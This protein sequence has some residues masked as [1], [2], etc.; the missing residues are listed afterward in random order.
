M[1]VTI[2]YG[3]PLTTW[4]LEHVELPIGKTNTPLRKEFSLAPI[5][6]IVTLVLPSTFV[7]MVSSHA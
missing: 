6:K 5:K 4:V 7:D 1:G 2:E 3:H